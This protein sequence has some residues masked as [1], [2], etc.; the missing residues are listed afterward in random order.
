MDSP[1]L[2]VIVGCEVGFW[3]I[4]AAGLAVRYALRAR[5]ASTFIL[6]LVPVVDLIL[7]GAVAL[8]LHSGASVEQIHRIAGVYLGVTVAFGHAM[9]RWADIR[10]AHWFAGGPPPP[11]RPKK[12][13]EA[14]R[15]EIV[16]FG[17]WVLAAAVTTACTLLLAV[18]VADATQTNDLFGVFP[19][20]GII[21]VIWLLT[22]PAW[23][24]LDPGATKR[25]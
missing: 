2:L 11:E 1:V 19:M 3:L 16:S 12:G 23:A 14:F 7:L 13:P 6:R 15:I 4:V 25:S 24:A 18:T 17:R 5:R 22:G 21:T 9:I 8:D 10:C 20:I